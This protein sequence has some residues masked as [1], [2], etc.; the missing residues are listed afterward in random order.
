[1]KRPK[2]IF[3]DND[4]ILVDTEPLYFEANRIV[5]Q[6]VGFELTREQHVDHNMKKGLSVFDF[7]QQ[8][9]VK[10]IEGL[11]VKRNTIYLDL[12]KHH[13]TILP[14]VETTLQHLS[15]KGFQIGVVT[16]SRRLMFEAI[17]DQT[18]FGKY[19]D[20][21]IDREDVIHSKPNP[22][23]YQ[24]ALKRANVKSSEA[25]V[26]EDSERGLLAAVAAEIDCWVIPT[27]LTKNQ[28]FTMAKKVLNHI[29]EIQ[30]F[31]L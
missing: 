22:E 11:M 29:S 12:I 20:F 6:E 23:P 27:E 31:L 13:L 21:V 25:L 10:D 4:G 2:A 9:E 3:F 26:I 18:G 16:S 7:L 8:N 17:H 28:N 1:M 14:A 5:M 19:F 24:K 15:Q 30:K